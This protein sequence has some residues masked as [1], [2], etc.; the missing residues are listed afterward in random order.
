MT[1]AV[2]S[3]VGEES[4]GLVV[5]GDMNSFSLKRE[6]DKNDLEPPAPEGVFFCCFVCL[7]FVCVFL[8]FKI[9]F[10]HLQ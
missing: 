10:R 9:Y 2:K 5:A 1:H 7:L 6:I 3:F 8:F 4:V